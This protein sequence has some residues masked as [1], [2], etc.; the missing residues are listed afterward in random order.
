MGNEDPGERLAVLET[1]M[2]HL[3]EATT[4]RAAREWAIFMAVLGLLL[5]VLAKNMG[6]IN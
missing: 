1:Q 3:K 2:K 6:W 5:A 4:A